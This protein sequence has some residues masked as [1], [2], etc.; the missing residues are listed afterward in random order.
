MRP[1][2]HIDKTV[3]L[4]R[5]WPDFSLPRPIHAGLGLGVSMAEVK[6]GAA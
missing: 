2:S 1:P 4:E 3:V 6:N 5:A